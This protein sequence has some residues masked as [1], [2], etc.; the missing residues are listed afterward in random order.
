MVIDRRSTLGVLAAGAAGYILPALA[1]SSGKV[2][3]GRSWYLSARLDADHRNRVSAFSAE[4]VRILDLPLPGR[5]HS[6]AVSPTGCEVVHFARRPGR[7]AWVLNLACGAAIRSLATPAERHF[8]GHGVFSRDGRFLYATENDF[9]RARGM[10]GVYDVKQNYRR[11]GEF[12]S[13][14]VGPHEIGLLSDGH[15]LVVAN[16]GIA[17][18]PDLPRVKLNLPTMEPSLCH[19]H[20]LDGQLIQVFSL[21]R[22]LHQLSIRHLAVNPD[23]AVAIAMQ[24][25]G[26][27]GKL[28]PLAGVQS[29]G[30]DIRLLQAPPETLRAMKNY[31]GSICFDTGGW[32]I[33]V[34]APRGGIVVFWDGRTGHCLGSVVVPDV[35]GIAAGRRQHEIL[36]SS[37]Q[38]E[39]VAIDTRS[40]RTQPFAVRGF[41]PSRWDNH[42]V[43]ARES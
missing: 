25:E 13:Y 17:T 2:G 39:V 35:C 14:G 41:G 5:G 24:Y 10:I 22:E 20:R 15:T 28:V 23:D 7:F 19:I 38:G 43:R 27:A 29:H 21:D 34:S 11:I 36:V 6:F 30:E 8:Y 3:A 18:Q 4:G 12:P 26:P 16:G 40:R 33:A 9:H 42:L 37:G 32:M 31:C 1:R